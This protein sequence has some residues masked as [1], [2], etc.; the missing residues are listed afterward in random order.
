MPPTIGVDV[1]PECHSWKQEADDRCSN[2]QQAVEELGFRCPVVIPVSLYRKPSKLRDWLKFYK[3]NDE[4]S[5]PEYASPLGAILARFWVEATSALEAS[6]GSWDALAIVP[7]S[8]RAGPHP[9]TDVAAIASRLYGANWPVLQALERGNGPLGHRVMSQT[10]YRT[11]GAE[12]GQRIL[13]LDDV[14]TTGSRMHSAASALNAAGV[15][16]VAGV[17]LGRR[18]NPEYCPQAANVWE[19]QAAVEYSWSDWPDWIRT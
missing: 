18:I 9:F 13:L 16:V 6:I 19:R 7:S 11:V 8:A 12:P 3:P 1:C 14:L 5:R 10:A 17:V 2:C 15:V 4:A